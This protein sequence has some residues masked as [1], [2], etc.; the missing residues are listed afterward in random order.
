MYK[1]NKSGKFSK[2][3]WEFS[4]IDRFK[5]GFANVKLTKNVIKLNKIILIWEE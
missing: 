5:I 4:Y 2:W 3:L 1:E